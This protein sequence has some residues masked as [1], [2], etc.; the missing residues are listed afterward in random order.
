METCGGD[1]AP[2]TDLEGAALAEIASRRKTTTY[3]VTRSFKT[4]PSEFWS[5]SAG[6]VYPL[7]KRL[8]ARGLI[9]STAA[10]DGKRRRLDYHVSRQGRQA[11]ETWLLDAQQAAG[12]GFDPLRTRLM[13][14]HLV[15]PE[16]RGVFL[17]NVKAFTKELTG[18][19]AF[20]GAPLHQRVHATWLRARTKWLTMLDFVV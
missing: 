11:L 18:R 7:I 16:R 15:S 9:V 14:L 6:A 19:P 10:A 20:A 13:Y 2:L 4:S 17:E 5:G 3:A 8:E 12:M 1:M